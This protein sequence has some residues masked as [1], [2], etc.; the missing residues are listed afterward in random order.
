[1]KLFQTF[2]MWLIVCLGLTANVAFGAGVMIQPV[3]HCSIYVND[4][5]VVG[6]N[7]FTLTSG[8]TMK[9]EV[10]PEK[11]Y[12]LRYW[13]ST[14]NNKT[15]KTEN[16]L[17]ISFSD[18]TLPVHTLMP[19][20]QEIYYTQFY[21]PG[22]DDAKGEMASE[23]VSY[24]AGTNLP[25]C[26]YTLAHH[27]FAGWVW[28]GKTYAAGDYVKGLVETNDG[29]VVFTAK[30][31][32]SEFEVTFDKNN[33]AAVLDETSGWYSVGEKYGVLPTPTSPDLGFEGWYTS[34]EYDTRVTVDSIC[35]SAVKRLYAK[36]RAKQYTI[37]FHANGGTGS[38]ASQVL[39]CAE[40]N[41]LSANQF[42]RTGYD[43]DGWKIDNEG[44]LY[45]DGEE[46]VR[47]AENDGATVMMYAQWKA[48]TYTVK[49]DNG[50]GEGTM[51]NQTFEYGEAQQLASNKFTHANV[52][53]QHWRGEDG[54]IY[55]D[56]AIVSNLTFEANEE[57][58]LKAIWQEKYWVTFDGNGA[59]RGTMP[60]IQF[61][62]ASEEKTLPTNLFERL[63]YT[64]K[65][66]ARTDKARHYSDGEK[67]HG[68]G[69]P[70]QTV[71]LKAEWVAQAYQVV[72]HAN[73][74][75][76]RGETEAKTMAYGAVVLMPAC[77]SKNFTGGFLGWA[78]N[79]KS[80]AP[81][82]MAGERVRSLTSKPNEVVHVH[83]IWEDLLT[84][85]SRAVGC[86]KIVL[87]SGTNAADVAW[88]VGTDGVA[89]GAAR[90]A[91]GS[92]MEATLGENGLLAFDWKVASAADSEAC[93]FYFVNGEELESAAE[94]PI[95]DWT[96]VQ[97]QILD[98]PR[99]VC[100]V[101]KVA[102]EGALSV[103]NVRWYPIDGGA[104]SLVR[105]FENTDGAGDGRIV[106]QRVYAVSK[107]SVIENPF[108]RKGWMFTGWTAAADGT[109]QQY[110]RGD[111][112]SYA[113]GV[114][115]A[116]YAQWRAAINFDANGGEGTMPQIAIERNVATN[117]PACEFTRAG[118]TFE[119]W[120]TN[121]VKDVVYTNG[122]MVAFSGPTTLKA[123]WARID[124]VIYCA[125]IDD[126]GGGEVVTQRVVGATVKAATN[127]FTR[128]GWVFKDWN[129]RANGNGDSYAVGADLPYEKGKDLTVYAQW[130]QHPYIKFDANDGDG[131]MAPIEVEVDEK[132]TLPLCTFTREGYIFVGWATD[133]KA[134]TADYYDG[135]TITIRE[136]VTTL[137][138]IWNEYAVITYFENTNKGRQKTQTVQV[139]SKSIVTESNTWER[140]G[141]LFVEWNEKAD[142]SGKS[143]GV[144]DAFNYSMLGGLKLYAQWVPEVEFNANG[145]IGKMETLYART[146]TTGYA[147]DLPKCTF[148]RDGY[149]FAGWAKKASASKVEYEDN[150]SDEIAG[151]LTL[152]AVWKRQIIYVA[153]DGDATRE[154]VC[155]D[156]YVSIIY[157]STN[158]FVPKDGW[159]FRGWTDNAEGTGTVYSAHQQLPTDWAT[160]TKLYAQWNVKIHFEANGGDG[161][162]DAQEVKRN[163]EANLRKCDF[164]R[165]GYKFAGWAKN[166]DSKDVA[167]CNEDSIKIDKPITLY[168]LWMDESASEFN[169]AL[170]CDTNV[171]FTTSTNKVSAW[172]VYTNDNEKVV[173]VV[174]S[175]FDR[176]NGSEL[177]AK[178]PS[179]GTLKFKWKIN[180]EDDNPEYQFCVDGVQ[181]KGYQ[182]TTSVRE[183]TYTCPGATTVSWV[184]KAIYN[185]A[186]DLRL[187]LLNVSWTPASGSN[188]NESGTSGE[189]SQSGN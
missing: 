95:V 22:D 157:A 31:E 69:T 166:A 76:Y 11:G 75:Y 56:G 41:Q 84:D 167:Y 189:E 124:H 36:W 160:G 12:A 39:N 154:E 180:Q 106:T 187:Y 153:N 26:A 90:D 27:K 18:L 97:V 85:Y 46:V 169:K 74:D 57:V 54:T 40:S 144:G 59:Q 172:S 138:A 86:D 170:G 164:T 58:T 19:V 47:L 48:H 179:A 126:V 6:T 23:R 8:G 155:R 129:T 17:T 128:A 3:N 173:Y 50:G 70:G 33:S 111:A 21:L 64:F 32:Q 81:D 5:K 174:R 119:G 143:Y 161:K 13:F 162:M 146:T 103:R 188:E 62:T 165:E 171:V 116:I 151:P 28:K 67:V 77:G 30:W 35:N 145:G 183:C 132:V 134:K 80:A 9:V 78:R 177:V 1:M 49:F 182:P 159:V 73:A 4:S 38:M 15:L 123:V 125:N 37:K 25:A 94:A 44:K 105:Y 24:L 91:Q 115:L 185:E 20:L 114:T 34:T 72:F 147:M 122:E 107:E 133:L 184:A 136:K 152:Y 99:D 79:P 168:A 113:K 141:W 2:L 71:T 88:I 66:W 140:T 55:Q 98:A 156:V 92:R 118:Y 96:S 7:S 137:Y 93:G 163:E 149:T 89:S 100:W 127:T 158:M 186:K 121:G 112:I 130:T 82:W 109:G 175:G 131:K 104:Y 176:V 102:R 120:A 108:E 52:E 65:Q 83:A 42:T 87:V 68:L 101:S 45:Q 142:G 150:A 63:G 178:L 135:A 117:L 148:K 181:Q 29:Q 139:G 16:P 60:T 43:F 61:E 51:A 14:I 53:F 110:E 10:M